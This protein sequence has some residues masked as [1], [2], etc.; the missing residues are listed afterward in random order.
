[1]H[2]ALL[3]TSHTLPTATPLFHHPHRITLHP[4]LGTE[5]YLQHGSFDTRIPPTTI[6]ITC[7][8]L[9]E[10]WECV[11]ETS[12]ST[13]Q[14]ISRS[15]FSVYARNWSCSLEESPIKPDKITVFTQKSSMSHIIVMKLIVKLTDQLIKILEMYYLSIIN[16]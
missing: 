5:I 10:Q 16:S 3:L 2:T 12:N 15:K 9:I 4:P 7:A 14:L 13:L 6:A 11:D 1:M 8:T